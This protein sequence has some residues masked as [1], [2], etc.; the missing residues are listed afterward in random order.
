[1]FRHVKI[2][3]SLSILT[4]ATLNSV[5]L[6]RDPAVAQ[7]TPLELRD[8]NPNQP[9]ESQLSVLQQQAL[10]QLYAYNGEQ[11]VTSLQDALALAPQLRN[12]SYQADL[13]QQWLVATNEGYPTTRFQRLMGVVDLKNQSPQLQA[14]LNQF[15]QE[16]RRLSSGHSFVKTRAL[17]AI[18][19]HYTELGQ[20]ERSLT[21]LAEAQQAARYIKGPIFTA[22]ALLDIAEGYG[23][24]SQTD[25]ARSLLTQAE[26]AVQ[27]IPPNT[28]EGLKVALIQRLAATYAQIGDFARAQQFAN[29]LAP[30]SEAQSFALRKIVEG[31]IARGQLGEAE[32]LARTIVNPGHQ[33]FALGRLAVAYHTAKQ[34]EKATQL[35]KQ[36][37]QAA[38]SPQVKQ[39]PTLE[40]SLVKTLVDHYL[41]VGKRDEALQLARTSL[42]MSQNEAFKAI[43]SAYARAGQ[44]SKAEQILSER[45]GAIK[46][47]DDT[48]RSAELAN[49]LKIAEESQQFEWVRKEWNRIIKINYGLQ[50]WQIESLAKAYAKTGKY[51]QAVQWVKQLPLEYRPQIEVK[52]LTTIALVAHQA[53]QTTWANRSLQQTLASIDPL[54]KAYTDRIN[55]EG[56]N[57]FE[58]DRFKPQALAYVA[59]VYAQTGQMEKSSQLLKQVSQLDVNL[60]DPSIAVPTDN[61]FAIF[62]ESG[63]YMGALQLAQGTKNSMTREGRLLPS[64]TGVLKQNRFDLALPVVDQL[65]Q[66][67]NKTLLL[68]AIARRYGELQ[69]VNEALPI[70]ERAFQVAQTIPGDES[71]YDRLGADG[72]TVIEMENDRGSLLEAIAIQFAR[73]KQVDRA[74]QVAN[75]LKEENTRNQAIQNVK[76]VA[77]F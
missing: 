33:G 68:L 56:G 42:K 18:A 30:K 7:Y 9:V 38:Q 8:C 17:A 73:F 39:N 67:N 75:T 29:Q 60:S 49:L 47:P 63:Q 34:P 48:W 5:A 59:L 74:L 69:R 76:C 71:Q 15:R 51:D 70:L 31:Y 40:D 2:W 52:S 20:R 19:R 24:L 11:V 1:M 32:K 57:L 53:G 21:V 6:T 14:L 13:V 77:G 10:D 45:L 46:D 65:T 4:I 12:S 37:T 61:P 23:A 43:I 36:A 3:I 64:A 41:Q 55:Q 66:A 62:S 25:G 27:Q 50:D 26:Q 22:N 54:A 16:T 28:S 35:L 44:T 58:I 72:G